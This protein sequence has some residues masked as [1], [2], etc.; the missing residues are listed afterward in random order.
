MSDQWPYG[1]PIF[2]RSH[3][4]ISPDGSIVAEVN[5]AS[6]VSMSNPTVGTLVISTGLRLDQCNPSF[7]W[8]DDSRY[9]A[10]PRYFRRLGLFRR[11]RLAVVDLV[12]RRVVV[13]RRAA[14]YFQPESFCGGLL[15]VVQEPFRAAKRVSWRVPEELTAFKPL[16]VAWPAATQPGRNPV[17]DP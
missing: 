6:E 15:V 14:W 8:S 13:S 16:S 7:L 1:L 9:L 5:P 17:G 3:R 12:Q 10:V 2:R 4:A 11:Q